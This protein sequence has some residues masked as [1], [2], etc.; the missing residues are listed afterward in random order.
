VTSPLMGSIP[1]Y[2]NLF[3]PRTIQLGLRLVF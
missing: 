2:V 3:N 1:P